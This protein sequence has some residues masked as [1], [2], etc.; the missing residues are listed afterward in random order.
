M[1]VDG[2]KLARAYA[3]LKSLKTNLPPSQS[4]VVESYVTE[5]HGALDSLAQMGIDVAEFRVPQDQV[6]PPLAIT[7]GRNSAYTT[8]YVERNLLL[9]KVDAVLNYL[10]MIMTRESPRLGFEGPKEP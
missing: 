10:E 4:R 8:R 7:P 2:D 1:A 5:F 3:R 6:R 9:V